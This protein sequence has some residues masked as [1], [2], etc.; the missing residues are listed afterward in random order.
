MAARC[1]EQLRLQAAAQAWRVYLA[2]EI[3][4]VDVGA[5]VPEHGRERGWPALILG[6]RKERDG[7]Q[8][9]GRSSRRQ[10][11]G[12]GAAEQRERGRDNS[13]LRSC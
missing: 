11:R 4:G 12:A 5:R 7:R 6:L 3:F 1:A 10:L 9:G 8:L 13:G 2:H